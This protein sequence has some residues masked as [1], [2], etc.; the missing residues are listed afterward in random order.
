MGP[1]FTIGHSTRPVGELI[2]LLQES[3]VDLLVDIRAVPRSRFNTQFNADALPTPLAGSG[4]GYLHLKELGG[5]RHR[6]KGAPPSPNTLWQN[7]SFR[8]YAD[9]AMTAPAFRAGLDRLCVLAQQRRPAIMCAE[10]VWWRCHRRIVA[11]YLLARGID[12]EHIM[13]AGKIEPARLTA[14]AE[15]LPDGAILYSTQ[16]VPSGLPLFC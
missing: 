12:V 4:I 7:E 1:V 2:G 9:Y 11:D 6:P 14:G 3:G 16:T 8:S 10:A 13:G 15:P 5:L